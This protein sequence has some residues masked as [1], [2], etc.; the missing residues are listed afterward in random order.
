M[1]KLQHVE[2]YANIRMNVEIIALQLTDFNDQ[3]QLLIASCQVDL[4]LFLL[5]RGRVARVDMRCSDSVTV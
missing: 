5:K 1:L 4:L 3:I 2:Q